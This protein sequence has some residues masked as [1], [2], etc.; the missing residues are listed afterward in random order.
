MKI[1]KKIGILV[2]A[3][4]AVAGL[5]VAQAADTTAA[6]IKVAV[7]NVQQ[8]LQQSPRVADLS[9]KLEGQ[10]KGRQTSINDQQTALQ[11]E[12]DKFKKE[13]PT[14]S[15]NDK[16]SMEKKISSDR[17]DLVKKVVAYQQDLQKAQ[18]TIMQ[19]ILGDINGIVS[20]I[21][22]AQSYALVMDAQ[23][24]IYAADGNDITA[25]VAKQFNAKK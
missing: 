3:M 25:D 9:K 16:S 10:F 11:A 6:Q 23:A 21:A 13:S 1:V 20:T 19:G 14:M 12:M 7:V 5:N 24:V 18:N 2:G 15:A 8:I 17:A 4:V 22:K